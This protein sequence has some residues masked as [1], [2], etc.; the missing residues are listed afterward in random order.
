[1]IVVETHPE[2]MDQ[3]IFQLTQLQ[4]VMITDGYGVTRPMTYYV[5]APDKVL[6][7]F[8]SIAYPKCGFY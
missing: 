4:D 8:D 1:M 3:E 6:G 7:L 5:E 2:F